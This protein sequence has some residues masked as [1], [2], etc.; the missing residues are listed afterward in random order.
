[1]AKTFSHG[2]H[3]TSSIC[4][5][6]REVWTVFFN[7]LFKTQG[8]S[9]L[10][11]WYLFTGV[12][13]LVAFSFP[14]IFLIHGSCLIAI[15]L[16]NFLSFCS[17]HHQSVLPLCWIHKWLCK[18]RIWCRARQL[19]THHLFGKWM[20]NWY[21]SFCHWQL[22]PRD[23][24]ISQLPEGLTEKLLPSDQTCGPKPAPQQQHS[25]WPQTPFRGTSVLPGRAGGRG[26]NPYPSLG[27]ILPSPKSLPGALCGDWYMNL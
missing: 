10:L 9:S 6:A 2:F 11:P 14:V 8:L 24:A 26:P 3:N 27:K 15:Y 4:L 23:R 19:T 16:Q 7:S 25:R 22:L 13:P 5:A 1:M 20:S 12:G 21:I 18:K 17:I